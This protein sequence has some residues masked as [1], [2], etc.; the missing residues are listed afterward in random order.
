FYTDVGRA[1]LCGIP[2][3]ND[4][5]R[6]TNSLSASKAGS[7]QSKCRSSSCAAGELAEDMTAMQ[8]LYASYCMNVGYTQPGATAWFTVGGGGPSS[9]GTVTP[10]QRTSSGPQ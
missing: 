1:L 4:C 6:A 5:Y 3:A 9:I 8:S 10:G 7:F 2:Y